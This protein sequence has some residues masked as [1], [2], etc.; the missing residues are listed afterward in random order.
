[1]KLQRI[2]LCSTEH[3]INILSEKMLSRD[4]FSKYDFFFVVLGLLKN[5]GKRIGKLFSKIKGNSQLTFVKPF[6]LAALADLK[7]L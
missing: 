3:Y 5:G 1:M 2:K 4:S 7:T 6:Y